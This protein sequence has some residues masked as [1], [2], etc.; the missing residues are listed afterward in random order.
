MSDEEITLQNIIV[1]MKKPDKYKLQEE[2]VNK[3]IKLC[4]G[5]IMFGSAFGSCCFV[6]IKEKNLKLILTNNHVI[7]KHSLEPNGKIE[8]FVEGTRK[9]IDLNKKRFI[10]SSEKLDFT[11]IQILESD[12][13]DNYL[14]VD[15][16]IFVYNYKKEIIYCL[17]YPYGEELKI[18]T[19]ELIGIKNGIIKHSISTNEGSSGSPLILTNHRIIG[20]HRGAS[21]K[22]YN[23]GIF[24]RDILIEINRND[25]NIIKENFY[26]ILYYKIIKYIE[27]TKRE[28]CAVLSLLLVI[29]LIYFFLW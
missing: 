19:G 24:M 26:E 14:E 2:I 16:Y 1:K 20:I 17:Q 10:Y 8:I 4:I 27:K 13:L 23:V 7:T 21:N 11:V 15:D 29:F 9:V 12:Y 3:N 5:K 6:F 25:I 22:N 18:D 28:I